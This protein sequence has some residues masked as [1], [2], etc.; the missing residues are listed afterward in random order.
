MAILEFLQDNTLQ[1]AILV[2]ILLTK[3]GQHGRDCLFS[4]TYF[5]RYSFLF[6][7]PRPQ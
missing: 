2:E 6:E 7:T 1:H 4:V 3:V 5:L